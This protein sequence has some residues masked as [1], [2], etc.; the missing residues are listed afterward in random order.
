MNSLLISISVAICVFLS[1]CA[2]MTPETQAIF[3]QG[4][5]DIVKERTAK[6][7]KYKLAGKEV[8]QADGPDT[9][10]VYDP[11]HGYNFGTGSKP[12]PPLQ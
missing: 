3:A 11:V 7:P 8:A 12:Q 1:G 2:G 10:Q 6:R 4:A 9:K 5:V